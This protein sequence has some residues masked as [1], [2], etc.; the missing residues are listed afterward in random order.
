MDEF[1]HI[2][3]DSD[4]TTVEG[5]LKTFLDVYF[6]LNDA[7]VL[8]HFGGGDS[9]NVAEELLGAT[10]ADGTKVIT[11]IID[12]L[13][14]NPRTASLVTSLTK[15]SLKLMAESTGNLL[16]EGTDA[17]QIYEDVKV[18]MQDVLLNV[19]DP[20]IPEEEK[21]EVVKESLNNTLIE[22]GV[23]SADAPLSD[24]AMNSIT[25]Y[26]MENYAGKEE[27]T[28]D[29]IN[30]AIFAYYNQY[31]IPEGVNP[32]NVV[33]PGAGDTTEGGESVEGEAP[34]KGE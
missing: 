8:S 18:G 32:D 16:P 34:V 14:E 29:D 25:D 19:N 26:V 1:V 12:K 5:D 17:D 22:S 11:K 33:I 4:R 21:H 24:E 28:D 3:A 6:I 23:V 10:D 27:L 20:S 30:N 7:H 13:S 31:G 2:F 9:S 15:F